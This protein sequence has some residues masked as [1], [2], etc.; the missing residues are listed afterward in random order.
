VDDSLEMLKLRGRLCL[1]L[2]KIGIYHY[3]CGA[4]VRV[5]LI[6]K[7]PY[8]NGL[9]KLGFVEILQVF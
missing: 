7:M 2:V 5:D 4:N 6:L 8:A 3:H 1:R 9:Q